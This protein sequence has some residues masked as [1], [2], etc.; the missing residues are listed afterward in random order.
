M[1]EFYIDH[2]MHFLILNTYMKF[3]DVVESS[4]RSW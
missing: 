3:L 4:L 1:H 2:T